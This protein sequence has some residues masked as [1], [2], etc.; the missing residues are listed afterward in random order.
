VIGA[1]G[2]FEAVGSVLSLKVLEVERQSGVVD[3]DV[4]LLAGRAKLTHKLP[5]RLQRRQIQLHSNEQV[6]REA[7]A[8]ARIAAAA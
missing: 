8:T 7:V 5:H 6:A 2:E 1:N 4:Q 3:D